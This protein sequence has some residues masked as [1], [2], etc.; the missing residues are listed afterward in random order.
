MIMIILIRGNVGGVNMGASMVVADSPHG[1][2]IIILVLD[3][4]SSLPFP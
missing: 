3:L 4:G 1:P 2:K